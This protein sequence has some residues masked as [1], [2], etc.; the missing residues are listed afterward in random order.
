MVPYQIRVNGA[1][2]NTEALRIEGQDST[3]G[4]WSAT[5]GFTYPSIDAIQEVAVQTNN[6]AAAFGQAGGGLFNLTMRSGTNRFHGSAYDYFI[7][8]ALNANVPFQNVRPVRRRNDYGFTVGGPVWLPK[9]YNGHDKT[10]FFF[11]WE[12]Y[13][14][15]QT[16]NNLPQTVPTAASRAGDFTSALTTRAPLGT[17]SLGRPMLEGEIYDPATQRV[18]NGFTVRDPF[19]NNKID[20][21]R[22]DPISA[23]IQGFLPQQNQPGLVNNYLPVFVS[24]SIYSI[25]AFKID[26]LISSRHKVSFY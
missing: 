15:K 12:Q 22:F 17:D 7:N 2:G 16:Y 25:P 24:P 9:V 3:S 19:P 14:D 18:V 11:N 4:L 13:R 26:H 23:K 5:P 8:D 10:F 21:A 6:Y 1:P 20:P